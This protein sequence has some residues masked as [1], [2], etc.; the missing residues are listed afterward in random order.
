VL[1]LDLSTTGL[2]LETFGDLAD[3]ETI[4]LSIPGAGDVDAVV[5]WSSGRLFGC[6]FLEPISTA[7]V[8]A[9]L[10]RAPYEPQSASSPSHP[11]KNRPLA[12]EAPSEPSVDGKLSFSVKLRW[13]VGLSLLS[14][15][16]FAGIASL[17]WT[18]L[19]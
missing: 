4:S 7:A 14:W 8:S 15:A 17:A 10:L 13:I 3:G 2:L 9:T 5:K 6:R 16:A 12:S 18:N 1:I 11:S 19:Y